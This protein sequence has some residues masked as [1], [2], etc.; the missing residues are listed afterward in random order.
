MQADAVV[1]L[2]AGNLDV[3]SSWLKPG[4]VVIRCEPN[5]DTGVALRFFDFIFLLHGILNSV[6][7]LC[8]SSAMHVFFLA[9]M[10]SE[11]GLEYLTAAYRIK[12]R[13]QFRL[14][15][16]QCCSRCRTS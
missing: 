1:L 9:E 14:I 6:K 12:V 4:A 7:S 10:S 2:E 15:W 3:P 8:N 16:C 11:S 13:L 5:L